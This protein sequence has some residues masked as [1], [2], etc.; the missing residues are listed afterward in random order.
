MSDAHFNCERA[1]LMTRMNMSAAFCQESIQPKFNTKL[2]SFSSDEHPFIIISEGRA[3]SNYCSLFINRD[4]QPKRP[5]RA[6]QFNS[7]I[8][9]RRFKVLVHDSALLEL[10]RCIA[11]LHLSSKDEP[12]SDL[13]VVKHLASQCPRGVLT[14][15]YL[16]FP[17]YPLSGST[18]LYTLGILSKVLSYI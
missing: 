16:F 15:Y 7:V 12:S 2:S 8:I 5:L 11:A 6:L 1:W 13:P 17:L 4:N 18:A 14:I 10:K 3:I 9:I